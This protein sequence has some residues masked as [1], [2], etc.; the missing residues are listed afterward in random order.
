MEAE[1]ED[2]MDFEEAE[3]KVLG[4]RTTPMRLRIRISAVGED[5]RR[6]ARA[7]DEM[8]GIGSYKIDGAADELTV[9]WHSRL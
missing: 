9:R 3:V 2:K 5:R 7:V 4:A 1:T 6:L 8:G